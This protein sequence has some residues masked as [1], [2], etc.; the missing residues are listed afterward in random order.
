M[1]MMLMMRML[2]II[3][4]QARRKKNLEIISNRKPGVQ[5]RSSPE[6]NADWSHNYSNIF[7]AL[8][9][10]YVPFNLPP[11]GIHNGKR[12]QMFVLQHPI[13]LNNMRVEEEH[14]YQSDKHWPYWA[15]YV[16]CLVMDTFSQ[17]LL[18]GLSCSQYSRSSPST[19]RTPSQVLPTLCTLFY[20]FI[21]TLWRQV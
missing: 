10:G 20:G 12:V 13:E 6:S 15:A 5:D 19:S 21:R 1:M 18:M 4:L 11:P 8:V 3:C 17:A 16:D 2:M 14:Q 7:W 9:H